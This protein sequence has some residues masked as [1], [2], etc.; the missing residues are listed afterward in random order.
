[1]HLN[2]LG[3]LSG[4]T[5]QIVRFAEIYGRYPQSHGP[6][7]GTNQGS[8][9]SGTT[10]SQ[11]PKKLGPMDLLS[12]DQQ[13]TSQGSTPDPGTTPPQSSRKVGPKDL[14]FINQQDTSQ[15]ST[16]HSGTTPSQPPK[17]ADP[18]NQLYLNHDLAVVNNYDPLWMKKQKLD[19]QSVHQPCGD[20]TFEKL[21]YEGVI[22]RGDYLVIAITRNINGVSHQ[23]E[24]VLTVHSVFPYLPTSAQRC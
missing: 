23:D 4:N 12:I 7:Q 24:A 13:D 3:L 11:S 5:S 19:H 6:Q 15:G 14:L 9:L 18:M 10:P 20:M 8:T 21:C 1:M 2:P 16:P 22:R 17:K